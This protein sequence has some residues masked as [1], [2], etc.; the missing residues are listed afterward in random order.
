M[1]REFKTQFHGEA[2]SRS[3]PCGLEIHVPIVLRSFSVIERQQSN[4]REKAVPP[5][6]FGEAKKD[7][8]LIPDRATPKSG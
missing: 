1:I 4:K 8:H 3:P 6:S 2:I 7:R 5:S